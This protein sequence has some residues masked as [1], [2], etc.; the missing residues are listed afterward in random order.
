[1]LGMSFLLLW[2]LLTI[3]TIAANGIISLVCCPIGMVSIIT[4]MKI[5]WKNRKMG[6]S[7]E[8]EAKPN[9]NPVV[10]NLGGPLFVLGWFFFWVGMAS[11]DQVDNS[12]GLPLYFTIRSA[13]A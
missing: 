11:T 7:W 1:M 5:L 8:Q 4:S 2:I 6:D 3:A 12:S 13:L 9:P 10:Y